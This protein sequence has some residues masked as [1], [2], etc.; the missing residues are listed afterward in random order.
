[1]ESEVFPPLHADT[2]D[3]KQFSQVMYL[4]LLTFRGSVLMFHLKI[5]SLVTLRVL[6]SEKEAQQRRSR[7]T[8]QLNDFSWPSARFERAILSLLMFSV[9]G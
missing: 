7:Q 5:C 4:P 8:R 9:D 3:V 6:T 1:M 2:P